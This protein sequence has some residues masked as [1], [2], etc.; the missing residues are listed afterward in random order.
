[1]P[2]LIGKPK[3]GK[4]LKKATLG[5]MPCKVIIFI[6]FSTAPERRVEKVMLVA[7]LTARLIRFDQTIQQ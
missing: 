2:T 4:V 3:E 7:L 6:Y 1:M 5:L